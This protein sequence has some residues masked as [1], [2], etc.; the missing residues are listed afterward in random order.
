MQVP[1]WVIV[2]AALVAVPALAAAQGPS[3]GTFR[4]STDAVGNEVPYGAYCSALSGDGRFVAFGSGS[5]GLIPRIGN[6]YGQIYVKDRLTGAV[7]LASVR[8]DGVEAKGEC[9]A[10][11]LSQDGRYV[12]FESYAD[13]LGGPSLEYFQ[14]V[15]LH[16][17]VTG[18]TLVVSAHPPRAA[19]GDSRDP[20][21][22]ADGQRVAFSSTASNLVP[23]GVW[24]RT[25]VYVCD[26]PTRLQTKVSVNP[27]GRE[28]D[29]ASYSPR[30]S[31]DGRL[32]A[33]VS[34]A[35]DLVAGDTNGTKDV[36]VRDLVTR[37]TERVSLS[38]QG[39]ELPRGGDWP[40]ISGDGRYVAFE[41]RDDSVV[42]GGNPRRSWTDVFVRDRWTGTVTCVSR[43]RWG[44]ASNGDSYRPVLSGD[45]RLVLFHSFAS[46]L[47][48]GD[49]NGGGDFF[50][51]DRATGRTRR[52]S[53][54]SVGNEVE[55]TQAPIRA[56]AISD[57]GRFLAFDHRAPGLVS[58]DTNRNLD[59]FV[60]GPYLSLDVTWQDRDETVPPGPS[61]SLTT[62]TGTPGDACGLFVVRVDG[63]PLIRR[64]ATGRFGADGTWSVTGTTPPALQGRV[65]TLL[66]LGLAPNGRPEQT[67][68]RTVTLR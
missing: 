48:R 31:R 56:G 8:T 38:W 21:I 55:A 33:F 57:D 58:G 12:A 67:D 3:Q 2:L 53:V 62:W 40:S 13:N 10:P 26:I 44:N 29:G 59:V 35:T 34:V 37:V 65:L 49:T 16:D 52:V 9:Y 63:V 4:V 68:E 47:V 6:Q 64:L 20:S 14:N 61:L 51:H 19:Y 1:R 15:F 66:G 11:V 7:Q 27:A 22:S 25:N 45:G 60:R 43:D 28:G 32:V 18:R 46:D 17:L 23:G 42:P 50:V 30:I 24:N 36:F 5:P 39:Q 54:D 41:S